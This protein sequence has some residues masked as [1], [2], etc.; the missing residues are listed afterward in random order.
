MQVSGNSVTSGGESVKKVLVDGKEYFGDDPMAALRNIQA[1]MVSK[2]EVYDRQSDQSQFTGF[3]DGNEEKTINILTKMG[4]TKGRFG[5]VYAGYG[6]DNRYELGGNMN[7]FRGDQRISIIGMLN[8][9]NQQN[10]SFDDVTGAMSNGGGMGGMFT[11]GKSGKNRTGSIGVN[12]TYDK[13]D[14]LKIEFSYFYNNNKNT[15]H[16]ENLQEYFTE[17]DDDSLRIYNSENGSVGKNNNHRASLRLT[18][19]IDPNNSIIFTPRFSWQGNKQNSNSEGIDTY[20][21]NRYQYTWQ[22]SHTNTTGLSGSG[23][24]MWRHKFDKDHRTFSINVG[25]TINTSDADKTSYNVNDY[26][27]DDTRSSWTT[28]LTDNESNSTRVNASAIYTEPIGKYMALQINYSPSYLYSKGDKSVKADT[29]DISGTD[30]KASAYL[31]DV[32]YIFSE[33]LSN[34]KTSE[35]WQHKGGIGLNIFKG[36]EIN[37]SVSLDFQ[38]A[39]LS[40]E[41]VYPYAFDTNKSFSSILPSVNFRYRKGR[42]M[43]MRLRYRTS[44]SAPSITQLQ[45]VVDVS[46]SR[47]Y[48]GGNEDLDQ[49][50]THDIRLFLAAN[51]P[52]TSRAIFAR[53]DFRT[54]QDY[55]TTSSVIA[56]RDTV[57]DLG[58]LLPKGVEYN[59]PVNI[60]GYWSLGT[61]L[62]LSTPVQ[63]LGSNVNLNLGADMTHKPSLYNGHK[64]NSDTYNLNGGLTIGS[65]FSE[66]VDFTVA[67]NGGY[68]IVKSTQTAANNYNYYNHSISADL[69]C[70]FFTR[71]VFAND[72]SHQYTSGMGSDYD[73]NYI[74]WNAAIGYKFF[75]DRR[76]EL[77]LKVND[78]LD[79]TQSVSRSIQSAYIQT[80]STDVLRRY[81]M[82]TFTYKFKPKGQQ[83]QRDS[84]GDHPGPP[85]GGMHFGPPP[86]GGGHGGGPF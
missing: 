66:N 34:K 81:A 29:L 32:D 7:F 58:V 27:Y 4:I 52:E 77:R 20:D 83:Q 35:Y 9:I 49:A 36:R 84:N 2:I 85:S 68:N 46:N 76:G 78:I 86:G 80:A 45:K 53:F 5:R 40:G 73:Q 71:L 42:N 10:F 21:G 14:T 72:I 8:N 48:S 26:T 60:D 18:W 16:S 6:T 79:N 23:D 56:S 37:G 28:Q 39:I 1:D 44:T 31:D 51:N 59:K 3:S 25:T 69:N 67:Y 19:T 13:Q 75:K 41:Q 74:S 11:A 82:L 47:T 33:S 50:Y 64:V 30:Y 24:L 65:S 15:N 38:R 63:W 70:L 17:F 57:I 61:N 55:I 12:Y 22:D 62:T 43:H 54:T